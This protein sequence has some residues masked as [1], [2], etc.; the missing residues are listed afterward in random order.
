MKNNFEQIPQ[1]GENKMEKINISPEWTE[2]ERN[3]LKALINQKINSLNEEDEKLRET[4]K[5]EVPCFREIRVKKEGYK[6]ILDKLREDV[7]S[8]FLEQ[9]RQNFKEFI[10]HF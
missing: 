3:E 8:K 4:I 6:E 9:N 10:L 7:P 2:E 1:Q 5:Y